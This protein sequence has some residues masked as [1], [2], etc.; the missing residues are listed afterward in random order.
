MEKTGEGKLERYLRSGGESRG[1]HG[2][3]RGVE[4]GD[5]I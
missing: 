4:S 1:N 2:R 3:K 5:G